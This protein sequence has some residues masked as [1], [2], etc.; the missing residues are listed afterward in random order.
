MVFEFG[1]GGRAVS[2]SEKPVEPR[3]PCAVADLYFYDNSVVEMPQCLKPSARWELKIRGL[4]NLQL[5]EGRL[6]VEVFGRGVV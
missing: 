6:H 3:S 4:N 1:D 2:I 5:L